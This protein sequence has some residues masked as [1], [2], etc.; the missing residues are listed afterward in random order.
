MGLFRHSLLSL[1]PFA[2]AWCYLIALG[3]SRGTNRSLDMVHLP[4]ADKLVPLAGYET[5]ALALSGEGVAFPP[6]H[7]LII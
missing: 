7:D 2:I 6:Q 1:A 5:P 3:E 4:V